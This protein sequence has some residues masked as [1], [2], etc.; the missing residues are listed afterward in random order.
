MRS[1]GFGDTH[2]KTALAATTILDLRPD[3]DDLMKAMKSKTR[4]NI[5]LGERSG[6]TVRLGTHQDVAVFH[7]MLMKTAER[8]GFVPNSLTHLEDLHE[9]LGDWCRIFL[10]EVDGRA[11][12]GMLAMTF[13]DTV[14]YKRGAWSGDEGDKRPNEVMHWGVIQ[15]A[16]EHGFTRYD[17]DGIEPDIARTVLAGEKVS[18]SAT[19]SVTRF[20]LGFSGEILLLPETVS[21]VPNRVLRFGY[22]R[23]Y[24]QIAHFG[25]VKQLVKRARVG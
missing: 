7:S 4:Y 10:A 24:P 20:K 11:V 23:M 2:L 3:P 19:E 16:R 12:A 5:R 18:G 8:Q 14:V 1:A 13:G 21:F 22:D 17:F 9:T 25:P 6:V 15:W